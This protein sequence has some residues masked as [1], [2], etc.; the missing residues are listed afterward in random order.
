[1]FGNPFIHCRIKSFSLLTS[2]LSYTAV[3]G[4]HGSATQGNN[5]KKPSSSSGSRELTYGKLINKFKGNATG[6]YVENHPTI[7]PI[8]L[9]LTL[10]LSS[11][12][13]IYLPSVPVSSELQSLLELEI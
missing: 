2:I 6:A 7:T 11:L 3:S 13:R 5:L 10:I 8:C 4:K 1:M 12:Q 9:K